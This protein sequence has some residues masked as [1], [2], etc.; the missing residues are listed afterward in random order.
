MPPPF[1]CPQYDRAALL[2]QNNC[3]KWNLAI[4]LSN[5]NWHRLL[6]EALEEAHLQATA[7]LRPLE[8]QVKVLQS[9]LNTATR[10]SEELLACILSS[11]V[12]GSPTAK[13]LLT[14]AEQRQTQLRA[15]LEEAEAELELQSQ[16]R[17]DMEV[18][19][20]ALKGF[21]D[22]FEELTLDEKREY[23]R[24]LVKG[25][26]ATRESVEVELY[27]GRALARLVEYKECQQGG[28]S[29]KKKRH[30]HPETSSGGDYEG[31]TIVGAREATP[32]TN[33]PPFPTPKTMP[34]VCGESLLAPPATT[35]G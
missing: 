35:N 7:S 33:M 19:S 4:R 26:R 32:G 34:M 18:A 8:E 13:K 6:E 14:D 21:D 15:A 16:Q 30:D 9:E 10:R 31:Y 27:E 28:M 23:L 24:L 12:A 20:E 11:G 25:M 17:L 22:A 29:R 5:P 2:L 1:F 3:K